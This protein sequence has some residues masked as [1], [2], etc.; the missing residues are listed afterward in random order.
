[1]AKPSAYNLTY[2]PEVSDHL[3]AIEPR[4][5]GLIRQ[6]IEQQLTF[7]PG[8]ETTN[9]KPLDE[10]ILGAT[11]ELR[12][13]PKNRFRVFYDVNSEDRTVFVLAVGEKRRERLWVAGEVFRP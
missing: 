12:C 5:H 10:P 8:L 9:R 2:V 6:V 1:M 11:W 13:G 7:E 4:Y 3:R